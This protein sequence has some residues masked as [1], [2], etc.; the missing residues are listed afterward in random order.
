MNEH[1]PFLSEGLSGAAFH[2]LIHVTLP[3]ALPWLTLQLGFALDIG[4]NMAISEGMAY[5]AFCRLELGEYEF[6][7]G[8]SPLQVRPHWPLSSRPQHLLS[9]LVTSKVLKQISDE[10]RF[11]AKNIN[12]AAYMQLLARDHQDLLSHY[13]K[14]WDQRKHSVDELFSTIS[15]LVLLSSHQ[16]PS[17]HQ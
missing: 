6:V 11:P 14:M 8:L 17:L 4:N 12:F 16:S 15:S 3:C 1:Y 7:G 13:A 2:A 10:R 9:V 5:H